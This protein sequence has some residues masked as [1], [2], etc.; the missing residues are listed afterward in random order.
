MKY[1]PSQF[2]PVIVLAILAGLSFWLQSTVD[3]GEVRHDGKFRH[4]PDA[5]AD[6][7]VVRRFD[8]TGQVKYRL[9]APYLVHFPDDDTSEATSPTLISYRPGMPTVSITADHAKV[10]AN[11][12][13]AHLRDNVRVTRAATGNRPELVATTD[14]LTAHT[15]EGYAVTDSPVKITQGPSW[16]TGVGARID[17]NASTFVLQS[18]V[19][20][21]YIRSR[22]TP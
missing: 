9:I 10:T 19:R 20:G 22:G 6:N 14:T 18:Q 13:V 2:F 12:E 17:T 3:P 4:D 15:E 11:G 8:E 5:I 21:T 16:V 7:I 1:W